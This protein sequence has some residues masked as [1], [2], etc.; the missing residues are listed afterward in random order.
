MNSLFASRRVHNQNAIA[1][2][3]P[4]PPPPSP[5]A[6]EEKKPNISCLNMSSYWCNV[7]THSVD[8]SVYLGH[9]F[10]RAKQKQ[11]QTEMKINWYLCESVCVAMSMLCTSDKLA[12]RFCPIFWRGNATLWYT[13]SSCKHT[14]NVADTEARNQ[15]HPYCAWER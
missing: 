6:D 12:R 2:H 15:C 7:N 4:A 5:L 1:Y 14:H 11:N 9:T 10:H 13:R 3:I 8:I